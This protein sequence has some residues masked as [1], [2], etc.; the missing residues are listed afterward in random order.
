MPAAVTLPCEDLPA[1]FVA[2][3]AADL[4]PGLVLRDC[5]ELQQLGLCVVRRAQRHCPAACGSCPDQP[6]V[7]PSHTATPCVSGTATLLAAAHAYVELRGES[8]FGLNSSEVWR[9]SQLGTPL[10]NLA[11]S[12]L[13]LWQAGGVCAADWYPVQAAT[14]DPGGGVTQHRPRPQPHS[15]VASRSPVLP[16]LSK[17]CSLGDG[18]PQPMPRELLVAQA[19]LQELGLSAPELG[20][21]AAQ[22]AWQAASSSRADASWMAAPEMISTASG[23]HVPRRWCELSVNYIVGGRHD[24]LMDLH[25][26]VAEK[27]PELGPQA[28]ARAQPLCP[29][30]P[31]YGLIKGRV[32]DDLLAPGLA[33]TLRRTWRQIATE[34]RALQFQG[35][36]WPSISS[37]GTWQSTVLYRRA[38]GWTECARMPL[39]CR[40]LHG[41]LRTDQPGGAREL[42]EGLHTRSGNE[43]E[44]AVFSL[45]GRSHVPPHLGSSARVN[46]HLCLL[47]CLDSYL[48]LGGGQALGGER[49]RYSEGELIAFDDS[50]LHGIENLG[51]TSRVVLVIGVL[52]P[53]LTAAHNQGTACGWEI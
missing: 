51:T 37:M 32:V 38:H 33:A 44:V 40:L 41:R 1:K 43:E 45:R 26:A 21:V 4:I 14:I 22:M 11:S 50:T 31:R 2:R 53:G 47:N 24:L 17:K 18:S 15:S 23:P 46:V 20:A 7:V 3:L 42:H 34:A 49:M 12:A 8:W 39:T 52:H 19:A 29:P 5:N 9:D 35:N 28:W 16:V 13:A 10:S 6:P 27:W 48:E 25:T 30:L 36:A